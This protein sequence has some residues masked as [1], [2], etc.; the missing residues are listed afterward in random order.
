MDSH[1]RAGPERVAGRLSARLAFADPEE[2]KT[3]GAHGLL[4]TVASE[5]ARIHTAVYETFVAYPLELRL[6]A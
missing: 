6:P 1:G 5:C 2:F 3:T 4:T